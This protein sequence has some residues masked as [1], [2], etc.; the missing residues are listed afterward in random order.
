MILRHW[1]YGRKTTK[2]VLGKKLGKGISKNYS[3]NGESEVF[4]SGHVGDCIRGIG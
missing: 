1:K 2:R 4:M 3:L